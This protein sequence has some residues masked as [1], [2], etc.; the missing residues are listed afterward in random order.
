MRAA[1][2]AAAAAGDWTLALQERFR[3]VVRGLEER[4]VIE[5]RPGWTAAEAAAGAGRALPDLAEQ[6]RAGASR[7]DGVTY[8]GRRADAAAYQQIAALDAAVVESRPRRDKP[9]STPTM[10]APR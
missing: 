7:F 5:P 4:T 3:A 9:A 2:E 6:L 10:A 1:A 8:G